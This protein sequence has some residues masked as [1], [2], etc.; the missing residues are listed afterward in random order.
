MIA[1]L[2]LL[3]SLFGDSQKASVAL[4]GLAI[5]VKE[6]RRAL[7]NQR[8]DLDLAV[9]QLATFTGSLDLS[10]KEMAQASRAEL[11]STRDRTSSLDKR[12]S[13]LESNQKSLLADLKTLKEHL[14]ESEK[15]LA[16]ATTRLNLLEKEFA[17]DMKGLKNSLQTM[18]ALLQKESG[19]S[20]T[21]TVQPGDSLGKIAQEQNTTIRKIKELNAL[22]SDQIRPGQKLTLN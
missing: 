8:K 20:K 10:K 5:E 19:A 18:M 7:D 17:A 15:S 22:T 11:D 13:S 12:L 2:L 6:L 3:G 4:E 14:S 1:L 16:A 9:D 21:Y